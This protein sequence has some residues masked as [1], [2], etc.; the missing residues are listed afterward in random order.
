MAF[1]PVKMAGSKVGDPRLTLYVAE[2]PTYGYIFFEYLRE[3]LFRA[4]KIL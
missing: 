4:G 2:P 3:I 1:E